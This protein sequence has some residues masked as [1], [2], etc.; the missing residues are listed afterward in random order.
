MPMIRGRGRRATNAATTWPTTSERYFKPTYSAPAE[1]PRGISSG[2]DVLFNE[3]TQ[4]LTTRNGS[5]SYLWSWSTERVGGARHAAVTTTRTVTNTGS[6]GWTD[7]L[8]HVTDFYAGS[9]DWEIKVPTS[10]TMSGQ[11]QLASDID[12]SSRRLYVTFSGTLPTIDVMPSEATLGGC[13]VW[14]LTS[15]VSMVEIDHANCPKLTL[16][17]IVL[18]PGGLIAQAVIQFNRYD[19]GVTTTAHLPSELVLD[20]CWIDCSLTSYQCRRGLLL[21]GRKVAI[22]ETWL[23]E[24]RS[25][26]FESVAIAGYSGSQFIFMRNVMAESKSIGILWGGADPANAATTAGALNPGDILAVNVCCNKKLSWMTENGG[27][28][29]AGIKNG[30]EA[31]NCSRWFIWNCITNRHANTGQAYSMIFQNL[32]EGSD[33]NGPYNINQ[34]IVVH[35]HEFREVQNGLDLV[36]KV[37]YDLA[38]LPTNRTARMYF[39]NFM[40]YDLGR[41]WLAGGYVATP[42]LLAANI[43]NA[44]IENWTWLTYGGTTGGV[45]RSI[46]ESTDSG[47]KRTGTI[48]RN[49]V[50]V[51]GFGMYTDLGSAIFGLTGF[52]QS[53]LSGDVTYEGNAFHSADAGIY[54]SVANHQ[55]GMTYYADATA[56]GLNTTTGAL[57]SPGNDDGVG[58]SVPGC[59]LSTLNNGIASMASWAYSR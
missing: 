3:S 17:G 40:F 9:G 1:L 13:S 24:V 23:T 54:T 45:L 55:P 27:A 20:R 29:S 14:T 38:P 5:N 58:G 31:K 19:V 39:T 35:N 33:A 59:A 8:S 47:I 16:T 49:L 36:G 34:D 28:A 46:L 43:D 32:V 18:R 10:L 7:F 53:E 37:A 44:V 30:F 26:D 2:Y 41:D 52:D 4:V 11:W 50:G 25:V 12:R 56:M 48:I 57:S 21:N 51:L 6:T 22:L 15:G 42:F